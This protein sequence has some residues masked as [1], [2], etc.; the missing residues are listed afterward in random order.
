MNV[1]KQKITTENA[2]IERNELRL[3]TDKEENH[4]LSKSK[5]VLDRLMRSVVPTK[6]S[7]K[8]NKKIIVNCT[9][10]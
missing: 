5:N 10:P 1:S 9:S 7:K 8:N 6:W 2:S 3:K 4:T